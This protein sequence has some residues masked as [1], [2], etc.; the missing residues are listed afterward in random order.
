[1]KLKYDKAY[2]R[3]ACTT[4]VTTQKTLR[5]PK[6]WGFDAKKKKT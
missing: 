2:G 5:H 6:T 4:A 1:M 3:K